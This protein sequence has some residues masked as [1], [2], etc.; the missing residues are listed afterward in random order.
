MLY[1]GL[2]DTDTLRTPGTGQL[3]RGIAAMLAED[4]QRH[5]CRISGVVRQQ[6]FYD[7]R[8][9]Y[10][11]NNSSA[12]IMLTNVSETGNEQAQ[13]AEEC[14][15][16]AIGERVR[17]FMQAHFQPGSD[18]GLCVSTVAPLAFTAFGRRAQRELVTQAEARNLAIEHGAL[19]EGLGGTE[20][21]VI[22]ALAAVGLAASGEDGR[23][24]LVGR[25]RELT[26]LQPIAA[27]LKAGIAEVQTVEGMPVSEGLVL[28]DRLRP[29]RRHGQPIAIVAWSE[30]H[31]GCW[32]PLKLD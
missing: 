5:E 2:D 12:C 18:P 10:T 22:G 8:V 17:T 7:P 21:G 26:G 6:L 28:T 14:L 19:L 4:Y 9:P 16:Q 31:G 11:K 24:I 20:D 29:A 23:Y 13:R 3:A 32:L 27:L 15:I 25:S 30:E 1:I